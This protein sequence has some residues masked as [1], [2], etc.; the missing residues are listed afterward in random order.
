MITHPGLIPPYN[1]ISNSSR[2][3][4]PLHKKRLDR[5]WIFLPIC[6]GCFSCGLKTSSQ[7]RERSMGIDIKPY[8]IFFHLQSTILHRAF[9]FPSQHRKNQAHKWCLNICFSL[10]PSDFS[11]ATFEFEIK[12]LR[13]LKTNKD[14]FCTIFMW[15]TRLTY[16]F[17]N[18]IVFSMGNLNMWSKQTMFELKMA[19]E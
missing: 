16:I 7:S 12:G 1:P 4:C 5:E 13:K 3:R 17:E 11:I 8:T 2:R 19:L 10:W 18:Y 6:A 14:M 9:L 15:M